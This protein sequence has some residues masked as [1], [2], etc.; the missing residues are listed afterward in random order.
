MYSKLRSFNGCWTCRVRRKKCAENRPI[1]D[2]C[3]ALQITCYYE[4]EKPPW[5][6][7]AVRQTN[8]MEEIK[9]QVK[10]SA[11]QKLERKH[12]EI[13]QAEA[14]NLGHIDTESPPT[15]VID[16]TIHLQT[17]ILFLAISA[18]PLPLNLAT[19]VARCCRIRLCKTRR[20]SVKGR[21]IK[22]YICL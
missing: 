15:D 5:M 6:D 1:C 18:L 17:S 19:I 12:L 3:Q 9:A 13:L 7:G 11:T 21:L 8:M 10:R 14:N 16:K 22:S 2:T 20:Q 4:E